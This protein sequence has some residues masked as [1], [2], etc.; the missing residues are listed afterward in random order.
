LQGRVNPRSIWNNAR[1]YRLVSASFSFHLLYRTIK[2]TAAI[3]IGTKNAA[4]VIT[5]SP[6]DTNAIPARMMIIIF[7]SCE[8]FFSL[9]F[10]SSNV[11]GCPENPQAEQAISFEASRFLSSYTS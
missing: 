4:N 5:A 10:G 3:I 7:V 8:L 2:I 9:V 6:T 1:V 11:V